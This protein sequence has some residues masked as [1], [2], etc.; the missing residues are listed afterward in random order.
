MRCLFSLLL[1]LLCFFLFTGKA[2]SQVTFIQPP[3][4]GPSHVYQD[5]PAY[6]YGATVTVQ[7][8]GDI[9]KSVQTLQVEAWRDIINPS[10]ADAG[11]YLDLGS[12][13]TTFVEGWLVMG[14]TAWQFSKNGTVPLYFV[15]LDKDTS[16]VLGESHYY[17]IT[18]GPT[19][20]STG[21]ATTSAT[22]TSSKSSGT[23]TATSKTT[24]S[25]TGTAVDGTPPHSTSPTTTTTTASPTATPQSTEKLPKKAIAGISVGAIIGGI[26]ILVVLGFLARRYGIWSNGSFHN[27]FGRGQQSAAPQNNIVELPVDNPTE[28]P[29]SQEIKDSRAWKHPRGSGGLYEV[30]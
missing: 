16:D 3:P 2:H 26:L 15:C 4:A 18:N 22:T 12:F 20:S 1:C 30:A 13:P 9:P 24:A 17:N 11:Y 19:S 5:N 21:P 8:T 6:K 29:D 14:M 7:W 28:L 10:P 23:S 25:N 27:I